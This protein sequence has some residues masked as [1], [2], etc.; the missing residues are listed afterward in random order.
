MSYKTLIGR[1]LIWRQEHL[2][3]RYFIILLSALIGFLAGIAAYSLKSAVFYIEDLLTAQFRIQSQNYWYVVYPAIGIVLTVILIRY[4]FRDRDTHGI[5]RIL[6]V[7]SRLDGK[8]RFHKTFSSLLGSSLTAGFGGSIGLESPIISSGAS[9]G[10]TM[11]QFLRLNYRYTT[12]LI[13]CGAAGAIASI[14]TTPIA[15]VIF[16]LEVLMLDLT[17]ASIIPLLMAS[18]TGA[19][20]TKLL[21]AEKM[22]V[23]FKV[24]ED[25]AIS[26]V[27]FFIVLG[28][29]AGLLS[30]Y[31]NR[32]HFAVANLANRINNDWLRA[33]ICGV[34]LGLLIFIFPTLYG[35]G[36]DSIQMIVSGNSEGLLNNSFFYSFRD[37][38]WV[39]ILLIVAIML[40]KIVATTLTTEGG[41]IGGI[42]APSAVTGGFMGFAFARI[43][44]NLKL[45]APLHE[46]NFTLVGMAG[47]L[48][49]VLHAPLTAIFLIAE[50][51]NGYELIVPLMLA[52][53]VSFFTIK[54]FDRHSIFTRQLAIRGDLITRDKDQTV[55][56][57]LNIKNV[58]DKDVATIDKG[59]TLG[60]LTK[61][62][63]RSKRNMFP[64][65]D[66]NKRF[67]GVVDMDDIRADMFDV[68]KYDTPIQHYIFQPL[69]HVSS[70]D[71]MKAVM[72]KFNATG[73]YNLPVIDDGIY[74]GFVS[75]AHVLNAYRQ[76][77]K[78][79]SQEE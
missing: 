15:A 6:Y 55:L 7:I 57:V 40:L 63:A 53:A 3:D 49:G 61:V 5:P 10:S 23:H 44:N 35:E 67:L 66:E 17:T 29:L 54:T 16:S 13:G 4:I 62:I 26:D 78:Y 50:M 47:V 71:S 45:F 2:S 52:T 38:V 56:T 42:F 19:I 31:F 20:T 64:V 11:A 41:G 22:L 60:D 27:P 58:I 1:F 8:M 79:V 68:S 46:G 59:L 51:T 32:M 30:L 39:F 24:T 73:Y 43:I 48:G 25:F 21:L 37:Q 33:A 75:R 77:L 72:D 12:L 28:I 76:T 36:Y 34:S 65:V 18:V 74:V 70:H 14:F 69:D 9:I